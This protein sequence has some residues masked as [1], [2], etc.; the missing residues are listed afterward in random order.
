M[1]KDQALKLALEA[2]EPDA[3]L[4]EWY[5]EKHIIPTAVNAIKAALE[6]KDEPVL[7]RNA[8][9]RVGEEL[10]SV[11]PNGYYD[12][13]AKE[14]FDWAME[15]EPRGKNSLPQR[16]WKGLMDEERSKIWGELPST[17]NEERDACIFAEAIELYLKERNI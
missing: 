7:W 5:I 16:T 10:S 3:Y 13:N 9:I 14:W 1:T 8:A 6:E 11:G 17:L 4:A 15:Q 2:L 12:M